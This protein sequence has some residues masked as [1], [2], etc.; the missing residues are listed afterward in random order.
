MAVRGIRGAIVA[1]E[2]TPQAIQQA[3]RELLE[4]MLSA[5]PTLRPEEIASAW[6]TVT[7][8]LTAAY[9]AAAARQMGW[10]QAPLMC[11]LEIPVPGGLARCIRVLIHWNTRLPQS[12]V[13]HAYLGE[14]AKL[15]PDLT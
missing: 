11:A 7:G 14:A 10:D 4:A 6:F 12:A 15:R 2:N 5:N 13:R 9:P 8:D 3:T 1:G